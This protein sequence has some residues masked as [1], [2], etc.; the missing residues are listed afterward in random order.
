MPAIM[1]VV[2]WA[3]LSGY[4][5]WSPVSTRPSR[6]KTSS[7]ASRL[8]TCWKIVSAWK[9][10]PLMCNDEPASLEGDFIVHFQGRQ[11]ATP[12][13]HFWGTRVNCP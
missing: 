1:A 9:F 12:S 6:P 13:L 4:S 10:L 5:C 7:C 2:S 8:Y 11:P 3:L